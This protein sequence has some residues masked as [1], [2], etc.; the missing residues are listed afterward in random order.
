MRIDSADNFTVTGVLKDL[1]SNTRFDFAYLL[2]RDYFKKIGWNNEGWLSNTT[3]TYVLLKPNTNL[4]AFA[5]KIKNISRVNSGRN[6][7]WTHFLFPLS[8]WHLYNNFENGR[9]AGGRIETVRTFGIIALFIL[10]IACINFMNLGTARSEQR[11]KEV[12]IR[13][14]T[15]AGKGLLIGQCIVEAVLT[16]C[17]AGTM[18]LLIAQ[19]ALL[20]FNTLIN[21]HPS[22][23]YTGIYFWL[24][25]FVFILFTSLLAG[26]YQKRSVCAKCLAHL[27]SALRNYCRS[28]L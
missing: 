17:I 13:K 10:L 25:A 21:T 15:G 16:A 14:V 11:A 18:A 22:I 4:D 20:P 7:I 12:G 9:P 5:A 19:L 6:D 2:S 28:T 8:K 23:P 26:S 24:C 3:P 27:C 1:P